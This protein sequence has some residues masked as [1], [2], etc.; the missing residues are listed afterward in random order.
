MKTRLRALLLGTALFATP[1]YAE[2]AK[3]GD[4]LEPEPNAFTFTTYDLYYLGLAQRFFERDAYRYCQAVFVPSFDAESAVYITRGNPVEEGG[5][6]G[7]IGGK[8]GPLRVVSARLK[9]SLWH[10]TQVALDKANTNDFDVATK[11]R[12]LLEARS[13]VTRSEAP[14]EEG[15][16]DLLQQ[17]WER[18]LLMTRLPD[19][20]RR[21]ID[22][23]SSHF[24]TMRDRGGF[25]SA[26][27]RSPR[28][29]TAAH[30]LTQI[31]ETLQ[32]YAQG[33]AFRRADT[34]KQL[35][36]MAEALLK[37]LPPEK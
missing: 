2:N 34:Q 19:E 6:D 33:P 7:R 26:W 10:Q 20:Q 36:A 30:D 1:V 23:Y 12:I 16:F 22:G 21:T 24:A 9:T 27:A 15:T 8:V 11:Q 13:E 25:L 29:G 18:T 37:R 14:I 32:R 5:S 4:D 17:A 31:G 35:V 28:L 3:L